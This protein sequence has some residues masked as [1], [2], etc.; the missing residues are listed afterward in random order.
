MTDSGGNSGEKGASN[1][2]AM[3]PFAPFE[4]W[5]EWLTNNLGNMSAMPGASVPWMMTPG[6][7]TGAEAKSLPQGAI[8][9]DPLMSAMQK[10]S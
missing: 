9:N 10:L 2:G 7:S 5:S 1:Q 3:T 6:I 4:M 8:V